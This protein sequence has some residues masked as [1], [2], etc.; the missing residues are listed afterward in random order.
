LVQNAHILPAFC[1]TLL[2]ASL[3]PNIGQHFSPLP[4]FGE[5]VESTLQLFQERFFSQLQRK[6]RLRQRQRAQWQFVALK[7]ERVALV[8]VIVAVV[9]AV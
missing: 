9:A 5:E 6:N 8:A 7:P 3:E 1:V 2:S 4:E